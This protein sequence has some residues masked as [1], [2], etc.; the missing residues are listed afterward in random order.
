MS[1]WMERIKGSKEEIT[2]KKELNKQW[3][4]RR[5]EL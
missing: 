2:T 3:E 1:E 5:T 4:Y